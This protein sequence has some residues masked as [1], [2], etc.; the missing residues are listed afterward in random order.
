MKGLLRALSTG[1]LAIAIAGVG[2]PSVL[3][4]QAA[5]NTPPVITS[6][7]VSPNPASEGDTVRVDVAFADP[8]A[9]DIEAV[10][11]TW[12]DGQSSSV[13]LMNGERST[14]VTHVYFDQGPF[15]TSA[16]QLQIDVTIDD[17]V[18]P[19]VRGSVTLT[20]H[21]VA[22]VVSAFTVTPAAILDHESVTA[23][24]SFT[25]LSK[26][27]SY[28][29][30]L[31]WGDGS[32]KTV[33]TFTTKEPKQFSLTH[34]YLVGGAFTVTATVTDNDA[35]VG[36]ATAPVVVTSLNTPPSALAVTAGAVLE[37]GTE[38]LAATFVDPDAGDT[39]TASLDWGD[40]S[41]PQSL[42][43][44]AGVTSF[45]PTHVYRDSG[46]FNAT[47]TVADSAASTAPVTVA[48]TVANV[49]PTVTAANLSA[50]SIVEQESVTVDATFADPGMSDTFKL[51]MDLGDGTS[52][53]T[54]LA[55]GVRTAS[56][57]HQYLAA[58]A[59][60][61]TV[62]VKDRDNATGSMT[63]T[64]DVHARNHA[65]SGLTLTATSPTDGN[66]AKLTGSFTDLD[67]TDTHAVSVVWGDSSTG[68]LA[69]GAGAASFS[70]THTYATS[71]TYHVNV[72]VTDPAGLSTTA[73][74][75]VVVQ[76]KASNKECDWLTALEQRYAWLHDHD[77]YGLLARATATLNSRFGCDN[78]DDGDHHG[79]LHTQVTANT[80][81]LTQS[82]AREAQPRRSER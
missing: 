27:D 12:G 36:S 17:L 34:T 77:T 11:V 21:N 39:H 55:A 58:G 5:T 50:P 28:T 6:L 44:L 3:E 51:T 49:G 20:L 38:T 73:A 9:A 80:H 74:I 14:F 41:A 13:T 31:D 82:A 65:P 63:K 70:A 52:W 45:A 72:T 2:L 22:P 25:D 10:M 48:V 78:G 7:T 61:I 75:D 30:E 79:D 16:D 18:N 81:P 42:A 67:A 57:S 33:Q 8:D 32:A 68:A 19:T 47:V 1:I 59:F 35:G 62:T 46:T 40:G 76:K 23:S 4:A 71:G 66:A 64:L 29:L 53:S 56:A 15:I 43:L 24:G 60:V 54:D 26:N 37:G 69:L